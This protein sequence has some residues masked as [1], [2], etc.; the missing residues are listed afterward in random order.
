MN[1]WHW[2]GPLGFLLVSSELNNFSP[3]PRETVR[4]LAQERPKIYSV[5]NNESYFHKDGIIS[6]CM[7]CTAART[8]KIK[9]KLRQNQNLVWI[10]PMIYE[11]VLIQAFVQ[12]EINCV[13]LVRV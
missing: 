13:E 9:M 7:A 1:K 2:L 10:Q 3:V 8:Y 12:P 5:V 11:F 4:K 6:I